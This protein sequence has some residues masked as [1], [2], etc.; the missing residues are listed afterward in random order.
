MGRR[1]LVSRHC[2][3]CCGLTDLE[4]QPQGTYMSIQFASIGVILNFLKSVGKNLAGLGYHDPRFC[5]TTVLGPH[6][7]MGTHGSTYNILTADLLTST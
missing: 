5:G 3:D 1:H 6:P 2:L 4:V 7:R